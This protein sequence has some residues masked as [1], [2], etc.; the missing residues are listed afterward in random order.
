M[1]IEPENLRHFDI[2]EKVDLLEPV[3]NEILQIIKKL[4][5]AERPVI[6]AGGGV[7]SAGATGLLKEF[8]EKV[9]IP[10]VSSSAAADAYGS[11]NK[12]SIGTVGSL[13]GC[14]A[15]NFAV[16]NS[17]YIVAIGSKLC[18]QTIGS[19]PDKFA[20]NAEL[21]VVD[22]D[23][24]EHTKKGAN[25]N[26]TICMDAAD[27]LRHL[28]AAD[29]NLNCENWLEKCLHWKDVF[30]V[31]NEAFEA[32]VNETGIMDL[33]YF[34]DTLSSRLNK[35]TTV[36]TDAGFE[37]LIIPSTIR[38]RDQQRC[39]FPAAQ[40]AMGYA[41]P[42]IIGAHYAG[43][44]DIVTVVGDG[45]IM[46]NIQELLTI[47]SHNIPAKIFVI[48]NNMYAVIRKRQKDLF[49]DRTIGNDPS[50]GVSSPDFEKIAKCF[51]LEYQKI[52]TAGELDEN[53]DKVLQMK[54]TVL[55]EVLCTEEQ[56]YFHSSYALNQKKKLV[57]RPIEDLSPFLDR[58]LFLKEM[59]VEPIE[60]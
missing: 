51:G 24:N 30:S 17:D 5:A 2:P 55:C 19:D 38:F 32:E 44:N 8:A 6:F 1:R 14:R 45:S 26:K 56:K 36:I 27:F 12:Y 50:D 31:K 46:M 20:R 23:Q 42:A 21:V 57:K 40:G 15:G 59:I 22:I 18:S 28:C 43:S 16:Q 53:L 25:I 49:R 33:Y 41:I 58:D 54:G 3:Y 37:E 29:I 11:G 48:N 13:G 39:L 60:Q 34:A 52:S 47:I 9:K 4:E 7:R 10:V 35:N